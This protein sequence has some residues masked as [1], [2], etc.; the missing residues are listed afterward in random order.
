MVERVDDGGGRSARRSRTPTPEQA[1][2]RRAVA[3]LAVAALLA[4]VLV[5]VL[6]RS[7]DDGDA[8]TTRAATAAPAAPP[9]LPGGGRRLFPD[10]RIVAAYG[11]PRDPELGM[12]GVGTLSSAITRL[13]RQ[14]VPYARK[15]R[16]VLPALELIAVIATACR[17]SRVI[18]ELSVPTPSI[19]SSGSRGEP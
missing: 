2:R 14:A 10:R 8:A 13:R 9:Q 5:S 18:A 1:R 16:P 17:R 7:G 3:G 11:S 19:P 12:L 6:G 15:T 4:G